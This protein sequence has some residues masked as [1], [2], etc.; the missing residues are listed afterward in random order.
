[1][2]SI[3]ELI[4]YGNTGVCRVE[5]IVKRSFGVGVPPREYYKLKPLYQSETIYSP[6]DNDKVFIRQVISKEEAEKLVSLIP[7][8]DGEMFHSKSTQELSGYYQS[9]MATHNCADLIELV[10]SI[11]AKKLYAAE[12]KKRLGQVDDYFMRRAQDMLHGELAV[13]L[14]ITPEEVPAY[15]EAAIEA[16]TT[17]IS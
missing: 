9:Y 4:V 17:E 14:G 8:L 2:Y 3:G 7:S 10:R 15:I 16:N 12:Q 13:A 11:Y 5:D 1:M 6:I